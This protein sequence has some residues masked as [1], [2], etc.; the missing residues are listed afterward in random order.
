MELARVKTTDHFGKNL[1]FVLGFVVV[2]L[3]YTSFLE[4]A[5][6]L[7]PVE[8]DEAD[9]GLHWVVVVPV[10]ALLKEAAEVV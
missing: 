8:R 7:E 3:A 1:A 10:L 4:A 2:V 6:Q 5:L 9:E